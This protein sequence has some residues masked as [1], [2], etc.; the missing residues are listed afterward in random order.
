MTQNEQKDGKIEEL[1]K[2]FSSL[3][4]KR[5]EAALD[6]LRALHFAQSEAGEEK[7]AKPEAETEKT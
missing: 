7:T 4:E 2:I 1:N 6:I 5:Q 3:D